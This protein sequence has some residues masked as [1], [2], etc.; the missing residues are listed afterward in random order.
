MVISV[1]E[2][3]DNKNHQ[4]VIRAIADLPY[5][6]YV[7]AGKGALE[8][9]LRVLAED[10]GASDRVIFAGYRTDMKELLW[11]ADCFVFPSKREG[12]GIAAL[13][14][15]CA[16]LPVVGHDVGGIRDYVV[17]G[18]TGVCIKNPLDVDE[19]CR[20]ISTVKENVNFRQKCSKYNKKIV[21]KFSMDAS[22]KGMEEIYR[23]VKALRY[24]TD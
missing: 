17:D 23:C 10:V 21:E 22:Q 12:L 11:A 13:E 24:C 15:M 20:A 9:R 14:G 4:V 19:V 6:K 3:N 8:K 18:K 16:G 7:I 5:V 2:L 1:G